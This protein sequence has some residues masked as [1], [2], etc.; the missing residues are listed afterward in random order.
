MTQ[1]H[2]VVSREQ[3]T[4]ARKQLLAAEKELTHLRDRLSQQR[5]GLPWVRIDKEYV[6]ETPDGLKTLAQLFAGRSQLVVYHF[7][8]G[9]DWEAG[10]KSCSFWA[11]NFNG[12]TAHMGQRDATLIAVSRAPLAKLQGFAKR[13]GWS[14]PWASSLQSDFNFDFHVSFR[15][16]DGA[17]RRGRLQLR[18]REAAVLGDARHQRVLQGRERRDLSTPTR[19]TRAASTC[20]TP[21]ITTWIC[22]PR[23]A[24]QARPAAHCMAWLNL[25]DQVWRVSD[26]RGGASGIALGSGLLMALL[27]KCP[28]CLAAQLSLLGLGAGA[29]SAVATLLPGAGR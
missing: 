2:P 15:N 8:F 12:I 26:I 5:R 19:A 25:R 4:L 24:T 28:L 22:C 11:D 20:S 1:D 17:A 7:M 9:P 3:W 27:P 29:A 10:C 13:L 16:E 23:A 18:A 21:P 14:F 6:F